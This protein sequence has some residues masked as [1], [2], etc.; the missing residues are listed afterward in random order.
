MIRERGI[1]PFGFPFYQWNPVCYGGS[2][3]L[4][5]VVC[6]SFS[7]HS[8]RSLRFDQVRT[9]FFDSAFGPLDAPETLPA[10]SHLGERVTCN[11]KPLMRKAQ[12]IYAHEVP[13]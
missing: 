3:S 13:R 6:R 1:C 4:P 5:P 8:F 10:G 11:G 12:I 2:K 9:G 7:G